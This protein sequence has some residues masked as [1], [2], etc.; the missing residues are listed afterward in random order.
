GLIQQI[1]DDPEVPQKKAARALARFMSL[2]PHNI[3]QKVEVIVE[4]FR[5]HTKHKIGGRAKAMVVT[6]SRLH[7]VRYKL[8]FDKYIADRGYEGI[9]SL[10]SL[11]IERMEG[12]EEIFVRMMNDKAF[13]DLAADE[14]MQSVYARLRR[15]H[16]RPELLA[17]NS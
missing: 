3:G 12:N 5:T 6:S 14:I 13:R 17:G 11:L 15:G 8:A 16:P 10:E 1:E 2:H 9:R 7:A 4:H